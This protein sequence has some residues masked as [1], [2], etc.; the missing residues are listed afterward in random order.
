MAPA[1]Y[2]NASYYERWLAGLCTLLRERD[3]VRGEDLA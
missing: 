1:D 2:L 3:L